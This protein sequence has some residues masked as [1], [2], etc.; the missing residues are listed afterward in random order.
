VSGGEPSDAAKSGE[1]EDK[2]EKIAATSAALKAEI[3]ERQARPRARPIA[4]PVLYVDCAPVKVAHPEIAQAV[5]L[6]EWIAPI[7]EA[8]CVAY[9]VPDWRL[10]DRY[11]ARAILASAIREAIETC[12][13]ALIVDSRSA[14]AEVALEVLAPYASLIVRGV[15]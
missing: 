14:I 9:D 13:Q 4:A 1:G 5:D 3:T 6:L 11:T 8:C 7:E 10:T 12:P 15:R 2:K